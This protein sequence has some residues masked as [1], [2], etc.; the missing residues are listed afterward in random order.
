MC[1]A[2]EAGRTHCPGRAASCVENWIEDGDPRDGEPLVRV[3]GSE[4][5]IAQG[6]AEVVASGAGICALAAGIENI[7]A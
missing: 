3:A 6:G 1:D 5:P 2:D 7:D 4:A